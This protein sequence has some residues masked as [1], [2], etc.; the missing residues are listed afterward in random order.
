MSAS[1]VGSDMCIRD[2][3]RAW[4]GPAAGVHP[5]IVPRL[6]QDFG[7]D[8]ILNAGGGIHGHPKGIA[9]GGRAM[10]QAVEWAMQG[11][12]LREDG[13]PEELRLAVE[14]WGVVE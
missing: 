13:L 10:C 2:W 7:R 4:P 3:R 6:W 5:G 9:A 14:K 1:V 11:R 8:Q 12:S